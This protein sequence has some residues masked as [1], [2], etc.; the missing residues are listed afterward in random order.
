MHYRFRNLSGRWWTKPCVLNCSASAEDRIE[1]YCRCP[2]VVRFAHHFLGIH[3][4]LCTLA[5]FLL[6]RKNTSDD[7]LM[8]FAVVV[9]AV[10]RTT[11]ALQDEGVVSSDIVHDMLMDF[12]KMAVRG[13]NKSS[14]VL[15]QAVHGH[16]A[17]HPPQA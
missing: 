10:H 1:H 4:E 9:Y 8:L 5:H 16:P 13:N 7:L 6:C 2:R 12:S 17:T 15:F 3:P 14:A 11:T